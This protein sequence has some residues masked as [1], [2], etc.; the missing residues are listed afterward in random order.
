MGVHELLTLY[1]RTGW[2]LE[3][4]RTHEVADQAGVHTETL[5]YYERRGL[6]PEPPRTA[7]GYRDYPPSTVQLLRFVKRSQALGFSLSAVEELLDLAGGGPDNCDTA[8][9]LA[10]AHVADLDRRIGELQRMR[11]ALV[12]LADNCTGPRRERHCPLLEAIQTRDLVLPGV[13]Q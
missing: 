1:R 13:G 2:I 8:H 3:S 10:M 7:G 4:M 12:T 6:I 5:R 11:A 9:E